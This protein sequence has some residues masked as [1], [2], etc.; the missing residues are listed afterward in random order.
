MD[1][2]SIRTTSEG[3]I[4]LVGD[5]DLRG[6][7][8]AAFSESAGAVAQCERFFELLPE[9]RWSTP[10]MARILSSWKAT[11]LKM[12]A[13]YGLSCRLQRLAVDASGPA[14]ERLFLAS[15]RNA[16]TSHEDLGLDHDGVTHAALYDRLVRC[17]IGDHPWQSDAICAPE[18]RDFQ[19]WVYR[20]MVVS[21]IRDGL[22]TNMFSEVYNHGEYTAALAAFSR[23]A[24]VHRFEPETRERALEYIRA[25]VVADTE[26]GHFL[27]VVE[28]L[29]EH[30]AATGRAVD[31]GRVRSLFAEY[32]SRVGAVLG[33]LT[34]E[35]NREARSHG[36]MD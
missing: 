23:L 24:D 3:A 25:H 35:M 32:L 31:L 16:E 13:I 14:R 19:R 5:E 2:T 6:A 21:D 7:L 18:A 17:F 11:H 1:R 20:N 33:S 36:R 9:R 4:K 10:M 34:D 12:L 28:A 8:L 29:D 15:A 27:V 26:V 22:L 30:A